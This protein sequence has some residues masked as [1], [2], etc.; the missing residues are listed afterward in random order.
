M[1]R[2]II[3]VTGAITVTA[4]TA[5]IFAAGPAYAA[6][7]PDVTSFPV[8][9]GNV[10][11]SG[12]S[13]SGIPIYNIPDTS[14]TYCLSGIHVCK[15]LGNDQGAPGAV[16]SQAVVCADLMAAND[17]GQI[18]VVPEEEAF[19]Q[20]LSNNNDYPECANIETTQE[21]AVA[22]EGT[23][24]N[25]AQFCGHSYGSCVSNGRDYFGY[26]NYKSGPVNSCIE[27]W[28]DLTGSGLDNTV[29]LPGSDL[30]FS[31][32]GNLASQH[33]DVCP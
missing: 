12:F 22:G 13:D 6:Q 8:C 11:S 29:E 32:N 27:A 17:G 2:L 23:L 30:Q 9:S 10:T 15:V 28:S 18:L 19:C 4:A 14:S 33:A 31:L 3:A 20:S 16:P 26:T 25:P 24:G 1:R 5:G 7:A 21:V